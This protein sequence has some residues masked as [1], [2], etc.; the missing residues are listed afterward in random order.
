VHTGNGTGG[1]RSI[2]A[3]GMAI[4]EASKL[5]IEKGKRAAAHLMEAAE[6]DIEFAMA[7]SPSPAPIAAS[8]SSSWR[9][10]C[11]KA[12]CRKVYRRRSTSTIPPSPCH[13]PFPMAVMSRKSRSIRDRIVQIVRYTGVNDFGTIVNPMLVAGNCMAGSRKASVRP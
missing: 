13:R 5:V 1:S 11:A 8:T 12:R 2:T 10:A 3:S 9:A 7:A 4:V 6:A